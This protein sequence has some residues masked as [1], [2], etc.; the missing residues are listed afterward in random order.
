MATKRET[1]EPLRINT[2]M[3]TAVYSG[4]VNGLIP[5]QILGATTDGTKILF[6]M[7]WTNTHIS[8]VSAEEANTRCPQVVIKFYE[9]RIQFDSFELN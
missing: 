7:K 1:M 8:V 4:F 3:D 5:E 6:Y 9:T 2:S